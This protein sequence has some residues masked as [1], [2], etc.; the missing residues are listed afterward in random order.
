VSR[1]AILGVVFEIARRKRRHEGVRGGRDVQTRGCDPADG[2]AIEHVL[3][4]RV[5][6]WAIG[7]TVGLCVEDSAGGV[8][9]CDR[10]EL[11]EA[12][13]RRGS[14]VVAQADTA[15]ERAVTLLDVDAADLAG[16]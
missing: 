4:E 15:D 11:A 10:G 1:D 6:T 8:S 5:A 7:V 14:V 9:R 16:V 13:E 2:L 3:E 12:A